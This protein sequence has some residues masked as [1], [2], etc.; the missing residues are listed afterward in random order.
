MEDVQKAECLTPPIT[1]KQARELFT[2]LKDSKYLL[3]G[4]PL[5]SI[6]TPGG[7]R[8]RIDL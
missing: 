8:T 7:V 1:E 6:E 5:I 4:L 2:A 3:R